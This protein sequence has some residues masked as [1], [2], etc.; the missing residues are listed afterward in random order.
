MHRAGGLDGTAI[1]PAAGTTSEELRLVALLRRLLGVQVEFSLAARSPDTTQPR[2]FRADGS[3]DDLGDRADASSTVLFEPVGDGWL[4]L[5]DASLVDA[6]S[7]VG[8]TLRLADQDSP[9]ALQRIPRRVVPLRRDESLQ[10]FVESHRLQLGEDALV[11]CRDQVAD[12]VEQA[13]RSAARPGFSRH[14]DGTRGLPPGWVLFSD[15][16]LLAAPDPALVAGAD[17]SA[18]EPATWSQLSLGGGLQLPG[19]IR[20]WTSLLPPEVRAMSA[21]AESVRVLVECR[22]SLN[23]HAPDP[24][25]ATTDTTALVLPLADRDLPDGDYQVTLLEGA[26]ETPSMQATMRLRSADTPAES[27]DAP[28]SLRYH[29]AGAL[30]SI[31]ASE[32]HDDEVLVCV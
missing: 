13:L 17:L 16:E 25:T 23:G 9:L 18:L 30:G 29:A 21:T 20:K 15:V 28:P 8:A 19:R 24:L 6:Q 12:R 3:D 10:M 7:M 32:P 31:S 4:G 1:Q 2:S 27:W 26:S 14:G 5:A 11:L 22:R